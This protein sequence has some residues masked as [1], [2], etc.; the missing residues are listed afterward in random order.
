[1]NIKKYMR[2]LKVILRKSLLK[3]AK[4][5]SKISPIFASRLLFL[6]YMKQ[7][8]DLKNPKTLNEKIMWLKLNTYRD[9]PLVTQCTDKV[10]VREYVKSLGLAHI[11]V[12]LL[13]VWSDANEIAW[14]KL[15]NSFVIKCNHGCGYNIFCPDKSK[16]DLKYME[17]QLNIW[18][19]TA[20]WHEF[21]EIN[22]R[23]IYP[24]I[25]CEEY[26]INENN[27]PPDDYKV[28]CFNGEVKFILLCVGRSK[29]NLRFYFFD[30]N[31]ELARINPDSLTASEDFFI[32]KPSQLDNMIKYA[33]VLS[34]PF[35]FVRV[36]FYLL[37]TKLYFSEM[38]FTPAAGLDT[39]RLPE[40][41][42]MFGEMVDLNYS[43]EL[44]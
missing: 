23:H 5:L 24:M 11:L 21:A 36:D 28:Y 37:G 4:C 32:P 35:P 20:F 1:M 39:K 8:L 15:P 16:Q 38:T 26:L 9:N 3:S 19:R 2:I 34:K 29:D 30:K 43:G 22:Y 40:T 41:D 18:L 27:E 25:L 6:I 31:W 12:P 13:G 44:K 42:L 7:K 10:Q 33:G 14:E 17:Q